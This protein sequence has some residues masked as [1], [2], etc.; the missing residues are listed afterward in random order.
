MKLSP[1]AIRK[2]QDEMEHEPNPQQ[3][4][5]DH[6]AASKPSH[7]NTALINDWTQFAS[8]TTAPRLDLNAA[9]AA[10]HEK[11]AAQNAKN[12]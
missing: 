10:A 9:R 5:A 12:Q 2:A 4:L 1:A 11:L 8:R 3:A 6:I 7:T